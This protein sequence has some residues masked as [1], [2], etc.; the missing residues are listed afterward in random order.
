V[1]PWSLASRERS[2][3][4]ALVTLMRHSFSKLGAND[5][6]VQMNLDDGQLES[7]IKRVVERLGE[8]VSRSDAREA[9][10]TLG[11]VRSLLNDWER[12]A[13]D[14]RDAG[15]G[16]VYDGTK[17]VDA[18]LVKRFGQPGEGWLVADSMRSV[19]PNVAI[20]VREPMEGGN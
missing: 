18:A 13:A 1:T 10:E 5:A 9:D 14:M 6:A 17:G 15:A 16:L 8:V 4:G 12:R 2:L 7:S 3:A 11:R 19:E 20:Q